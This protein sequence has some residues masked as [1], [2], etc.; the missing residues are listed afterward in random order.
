[1]DTDMLQCRSCN[2]RFEEGRTVCPS[3]GSR[4]SK[5]VSE[6]SPTRDSSAPLPAAEPEPTDRPSVDLDLGE[7][8]VLAEAVEPSVA[9]ELKLDEPVKRRR[10]LRRE[11]GPTVLHLGSAQVRTLVAEQPTLLKPGLSIYSDENDQQVGVD[12]PTPVGAID[13]LARDAGRDFVVVL[14]PDPRDLDVIV[15][16]ILQRIG[17]VKKH[18]ATDGTPVRG[19]VVVEEIPED[20]SYAA[21]GVAGTVEF[22]TYRVALTFHALDL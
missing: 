2:T 21:S 6:A 19:V 12:L 8:D 20:L 3:C 10:R 18:L 15:P 5:K 9:E 14:V 11:P 1:M 16:E 7:V 22:M 17:W 13:L 4:M